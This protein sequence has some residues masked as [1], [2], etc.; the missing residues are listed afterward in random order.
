MFNIRKGVVLA[1]P[2]AMVVFSAQLV[3]ASSTDLS[4]AA[5]VR[6][7][8]NLTTNTQPSNAAPAHICDTAQSAEPC[9]WVMQNA[10][11]NANGA[12]APKDGTIGKIRVIAAVAGKFRLQLVHEKNSPLRAK[13]VKNGPTIQVNGQPDNANDYVIETFTVNVTVHKGDHLAAR[14]PSLS[15][16]RCDNGSPNSLQFDPPLVVGAGLRTPDSTD[17]CNLLIQAEY[18]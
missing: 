17:G 1:I 18:K 13:A 10:Y 6:F 14:A 11:N 12:A 7:G 8:A 15:I 4:L 5:K 3:S 2:F 16:L 9:T